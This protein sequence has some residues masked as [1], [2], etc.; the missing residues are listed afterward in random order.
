MRYAS[1]SS[2]D[3]AEPLSSIFGVLLSVQIV[4]EVCLGLPDILGDG[5]TALVG[6]LCC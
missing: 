2:A 3:A 4:C 6:E 1:V 5:E